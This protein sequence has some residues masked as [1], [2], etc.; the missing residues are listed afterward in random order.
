MKSHSQARRPAETAGKHVRSFLEGSLTSCYPNRS[1]CWPS[2]PFSAQPP[3]P[4]AVYVFPCSHA[5]ALLDEVSRVGQVTFD[6]LH[7]KDKT[8]MRNGFPRQRFPAVLSLVTDAARITV[9][10]I[11]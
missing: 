8:K 9:E 5:L 7:E 6:L 3:F 2:S 11:R 4:V 1:Q 10:L